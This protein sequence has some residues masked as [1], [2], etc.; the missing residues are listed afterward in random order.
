MDYWS[1]L[2]FTIRF[3]G[4]TRAPLNQLK[5]RI[6]CNK[7][8]SQHLKKRALLLTKYS[9]RL[10]NNVM[11]TATTTTAPM[12]EPRSSFSE[13]PVT[14]QSTPDFQFLT[15]SGQVTVVEL[16]TSQITMP[17]RREPLRIPRPLTFKDWSRL[18]FILLQKWEGIVLE[19]DNDSFTAKLVDSHDRL[20]P[21]DATFSRAELP[22]NEQQLVE[23]G[24]PFV[25]T[26]GYRK[27]GDTRERASVVYFR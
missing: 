22:K 9:K 14:V 4:I 20:P 2:T 13:R 24:A 5:C 3:H 16:K 19:A 7:R 17:T 1:A 15:A 26:L 11:S 23:P 12:R 21:H 25:W 18:G 10:R 8:G 6:M 27:I